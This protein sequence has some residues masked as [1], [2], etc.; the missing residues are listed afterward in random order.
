MTQI[1]KGQITSGAASAGQALTANGSA[2]TDWIVPLPQ[3]VTAYTS[4]ADAHS[5]DNTWEDING[6]SVSVTPPLA[7]AALLCQFTATMKIVNASAQQGKFR[8]VL[9]A[10]TLSEEYFY[11]HEAAIN[12][13]WIVNLHTVFEGVSA[14]AHTVKV[15]WMDNNINLDVTFGTR[16][17]TVLVGQ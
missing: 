8:F 13:Y 3:I 10:G 2:E 16:R 5:A 17:L 7:G 9:D 4:A 15:Q 12:N 1:R 11:V 6:M 14:A